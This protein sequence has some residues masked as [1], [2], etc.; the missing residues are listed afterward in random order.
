MD[1]LLGIS[2]EKFAVE[3]GLNPLVS[4]PNHLY[5]PT[6]REN[7]RKFLCNEKLVLRTI[8]HFVEVEQVVNT[9]VWRKEWLHPTRSTRSKE[10]IRA[11][12]PVEAHGR[13]S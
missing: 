6:A 13:E 11:D 2:R 7:Y 9:T 4:D 3:K 5:T 8:H 1:I 12:V 10:E